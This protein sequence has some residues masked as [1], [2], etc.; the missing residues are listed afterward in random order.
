[1]HVA[2]KSIASPV[3]EIRC[4]EGST[5]GKIMRSTR[6]KGSCTGEQEWNQNI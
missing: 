1:M 4:P 5:I 2:Y 3:V 6:S